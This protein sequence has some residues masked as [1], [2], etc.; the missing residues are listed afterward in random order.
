[1]STHK[2][3][4]RSTKDLRARQPAISWETDFTKLEGERYVDTT[5]NKIQWTQTNGFLLSGPFV[6]Y[7]FSTLDGQVYT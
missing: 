6:A 4:W 1:M 3:C 2:L 7:Y 5:Q